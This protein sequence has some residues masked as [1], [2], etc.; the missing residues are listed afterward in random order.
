MQRKVTVDDVMSLNP[1]YS[2]ACI[3]E[4]FD[5]RESL[6][7]AEYA[8]IDI[9]EGDRL[10]GMIRLWPEVVPSWLD[11]IVER[12]IR[13]SLGKSGSVKW[14]KWAE[15]WLNGSDRSCS[16]A[17]AAHVTTDADAAVDAAYTAAYTYAYA[18]TY[19]AAY[20]YAYAA[21]E[22]QQQ[23]EDFVKLVEERSCSTNG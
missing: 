1:C 7:C 12:A 9:Y 6:T 15:N 3:K 22:K 18:A 14:E 11:I 21:A 19:A 20:A 17:Y 23:L 10:W 8:A 5:G 13:R 4:L 16:A 2:C